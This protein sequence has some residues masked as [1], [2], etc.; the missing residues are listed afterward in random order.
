MWLFSVFS[1]IVWGIKDGKCGV[2][3]E[4]VDFGAGIVKVVVVVVVVVVVIA[5]NDVIL[6]LV[7]E[8]KGEEW[9]WRK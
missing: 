1:R 9:W 2:E 8:I 6:L 7:I 5:V 3:K 4:C